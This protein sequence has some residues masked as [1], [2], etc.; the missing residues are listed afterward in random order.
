M[1]KTPL[2]GKIVI[3]CQSLFRALYNA[4]FL[5]LR[6][7]IKLNLG[8]GGT[9]MKG[10]TNVDSLLLRETD[11]LSELRFLPFFVARGSVTHIYASHIF[12]HFSL[13][14][15]R[16]IL[17]VC[18]RL[19]KKGGELRISVPDLDKIVM[20]YT[21]HWDYFH[22]TGNSPLLGPIYGGQTSRYDFHKTGFN[23]PWLTMLL[24]EAGF[25]DIKEYNAEEFTARYGIVDSSLHKKP[26]G[27]YVSLNV[28]AYKK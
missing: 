2:Y 14:D 17:R 23:L 8:A 24:E 19:L 27:E 13:K 11:L 28:V 9:R 18:N 16:I 4:A 7:D 5:R 22:T 3:G 25:A 10:Y 1:N 20:M 15:I 6:R 12:E 21:K 26:V